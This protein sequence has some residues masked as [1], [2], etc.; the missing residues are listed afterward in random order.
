MSRYTGRITASAI[1]TAVDPH[2][3]VLMIQRAKPPY[4]GLW[5]FAGGKLE[6]G[7]H[8]ADAMLR[9]FREETGLTAEVERYCGLVSETY[10]DPDGI[11]HFLMSVFRLRVT[12]GSLLE[13]TEEGPI[14]WHHPDELEG[15][16]APAD[17]WILENM[18]LRTDGP[19]LVGMRS[20]EDSVT[21]EAAQYHVR[22]RDRG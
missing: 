19:I 1:G 2:G 12:S 22:D 7:E 20:T 3:R 8:P 15:R 5:A 10:V 18:V 9:E 16:A 21:I 4:V 11:S 17:R 6:L 13:R 14:C